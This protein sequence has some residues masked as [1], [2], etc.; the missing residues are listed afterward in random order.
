M[1]LFITL[2]VLN[3]A[4]VSDVAN[5]HKNNLICCQVSAKFPT[6]NWN[7]LET[8]QKNNHY[9]EK[10]PGI[11]K[12]SFCPHANMQTPSGEEGGQMLFW[13]MRSCLICFLAQNSIG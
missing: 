4:G 7:A 10:N 11:G 5:A 13:D 1:V 12:R 8:T 9:S 2:T 6:V 3:I